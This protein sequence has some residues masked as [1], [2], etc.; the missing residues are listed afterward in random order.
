MSTFKLYL[1]AVIAMLSGCYEVQK[2]NEKIDSITEEIQNSE[3][4][5]AYFASGCFWC[6]EAIFE[7]VK[8]VDE[9]VSGYAGGSEKNPTYNQVAAGRT[10]HAEAVKVFYD[11][12]KV[13]FLQLL[14]VYYGSHD[15]TALNYQ[16]PDY[17]SQYRSIAFYQNETEKSLIDEYIKALEASGV[18]KKPIVTEVLPFTIF[19]EAEEY[20]QDFERKN[21]DNRY[22]LNVSVPRLKRFQRLFPEL[23]KENN[24]DH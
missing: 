8:G 1:I 16:G 11:P 12:N 24:Q 17:G 15:P 3:L 6:V 14:D 23:L 18:Y 20:H 2:S 5:T 9:V 4:K 22:I 7:S 13:S 19:Y 21:P 10:S